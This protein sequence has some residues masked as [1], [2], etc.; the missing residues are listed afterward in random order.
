MTPEER[1]KSLPKDL[2]ERIDNIT[3]SY[4]P[5]GEEITKEKSPATRS[6]AME[7]AIEVETWLKEREHLGN[8]NES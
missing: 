8:K 5:F 2:R 4:I 7:I 3:E 6:L 1:Y